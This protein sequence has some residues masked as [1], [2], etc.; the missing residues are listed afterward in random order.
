MGDLRSIIREVLTEEL[1]HLRSQTSRTVEEGVSIN[2][3]AD[4]NQFVQRLLALS[5]DAATRADIENGRRVFTLSMPTPATTS[6]SPSN[7]ASNQVAARAKLDNKG[8]ITERDIAALP[9]GTRQITVNKS[10]RF[11][12]LA[13]DEFRRR[14]INLERVST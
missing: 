3:N 4:L 9:E 8:L 14:G 13:R 12:P 1:A 7:V 2:S 11:T 6:S 5:K 10:A